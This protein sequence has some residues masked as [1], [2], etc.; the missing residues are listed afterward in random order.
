MLVS[1]KVTDEPGVLGPSSA[2]DRLSARL[3]ARLDQRPLRRYSHRS[4]GQFS[5]ARARSRTPIRTA[6]MPRDVTHLHWVTNGF[7]SVEGLGRLPGPL[8]WTLHDM[9]AFTGGCHYSDGCERYTQAC[10][11]CPVLGSDG[12]ADLSR[13][14]WE[15]KRDSWA[16]LDLTLI[17]SSRWMARLAGSSALFQNRR[18]EVIPNCVDPDF[19][20]PS[21]RSA[22]RAAFSLPQSRR[23]VLFGALVA[24]GDRRKG[25]HLLIAA[26]QRVAS[27]VPRD[28]LSLAV[29]GMSEPEAA[30]PVPFQTHYLGVIG[31]ETRLALAYNAAD[32]Y[33]SPSLQDNLPNMVMEAMSCGTPCVAFDTGGMPDLIEH[34]LSGY[35]ARPFDVEDLA[36]G[37]EAMLTDEQYRRSLGEG[38]RRAVL[39]RF[40]PEVIGRQH[41][42]FYEGI[43]ARHHG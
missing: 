36:R 22:A 27:R 11:R 25:F 26:L 15:R 30:I 12:E 17:A 40:A 8:V 19:F 41:V 23:V 7:L 29:M 37:I 2:L 16:K 42:N 39:E 3:A 38:A 18:V 10:G 1:A 4:A 14:T 33:V 28:S 31:S 20:R 5:P 24:A 9:W 6:A 32:M 34:N 43:L 13:Q 21:D 35:L